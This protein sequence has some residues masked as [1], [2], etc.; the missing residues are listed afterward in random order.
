[1]ISAE[2][3]LEIHL[4]GYKKKDI[5]VGRGLLS[6]KFVPRPAAY[7]H[8]SSFLPL[9]RLIYGLLRSIY[10]ERQ[11]ENTKG[12]RKF[13]AGTIGWTLR[14]RKMSGRATK[15]SAQGGMEWHVCAPKSSF[16]MSFRP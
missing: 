11:K 12:S 10:L 13:D 6:R 8:V 2:H 7:A 5:F 16:Q 9:P 3:F 14:G 4:G 15:A 1:M